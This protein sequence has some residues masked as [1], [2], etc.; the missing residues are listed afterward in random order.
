MRYKTPDAVVREL[1][2][3]YQ[4]DLVGRTVGRV[5]FMVDD[6]VYG[7]PK[8]FKAV[9]RAI[10]KL[11]N[12]NPGFKPYFG[13]Q[14]TINIV[15]DKEALELLREVGYN[16]VFV[17][18]ESL[19]PVILRSYEKYHNIAF[20]YDAAVQ[21]LRSYGI[22]MIS[23]FIFG[24]DGETQAIFDEAFDFFARNNTVYPY[25]NILV[26]NA[27]QWEQF[28]GEGRILTAGKLYDGWRLYDAQHTVFVPMKMRPLEL[29]L[30]FIDL[31]KRA[32]DY[33]N[34]KKRL[35]GAFVYG[36]SKQLTLPRPLQIL[37]YFKTLAALALKGD[38][39]SYRFVSDLSPHIL[40]NQL[41]MLHVIFQIDQHDYALKNQAT[42]AEHPF[43]LDVPSWEETLTARAA[44]AADAGAVRAAS[45]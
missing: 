43:D 3:L 17:G 33:E 8:E 41:S 16:Y 31:V 35:L 34:V 23:S 24:Q 27:K 44:K 5:I 26:P 45:N 11:N 10:I 37:F 4:K 1:E 39:E 20:E 38:W 2:P 6:N 32:F 18:L 28:N 22:E 29:Q 42:L 40:K 36:S 12:R 9:L 14:L 21:T 7:N 25:F 30:G 19:D 13:S 15:K